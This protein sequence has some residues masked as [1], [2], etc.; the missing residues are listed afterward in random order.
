MSSRL[1][2]GEEFIFPLENFTAALWAN[3]PNP[4]VPALLFHQVEPR[5]TG[6]LFWLV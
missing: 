4:N 6:M 5:Q 3:T 1:R 2:S